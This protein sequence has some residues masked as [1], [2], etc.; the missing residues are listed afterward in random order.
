MPL[1]IPTFAPG[2][3]PIDSFFTPAVKSDYFPATLQEAQYK[4][5]YYGIPQWTNVEILYY[6]KDLF[7]STAEQSNFK[8]KYGYDL[9]PP[10]HLEQFTDAAE[11]FTRGSCPLR[12]RRKSRRR[13][14]STWRPYCKPALP[15]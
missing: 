2:L 14:R 5:T 15:A 7:E 8:A 12:D 9:A 3:V 6:R 13:D 4:G 11:F 10:G 1:R